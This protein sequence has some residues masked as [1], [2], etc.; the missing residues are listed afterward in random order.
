GP[1]TTAA[2]MPAAPMMLPARRMARVPRPWSRVIHDGEDSWPYAR[3]VNQNASSAVMNSAV[4]RTRWRG[5]PR[6]APKTNSVDAGTIAST[7]P[8]AR[9]AAVS[10]RNA[11]P[12]APMVDAR[13][14]PGSVG[15]GALTFPNIDH[16]SAMS[17]RAAWM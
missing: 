7:R 16:A 13:T 1:T 2:M 10:A 4:H 8:R 9:N 5:A 6:A 17:P 11:R 14:K 3:D 12:H 15:A